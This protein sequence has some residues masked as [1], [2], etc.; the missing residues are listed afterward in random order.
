MIPNNTK[1]ASDKFSRMSYYVVTMVFENFDIFWSKM[2]KI[3]IEGYLKKIYQWYIC[4][5]INEEINFLILKVVRLIW[6]ILILNF[7]PT[8]C[9]NLSKQYSM[10]G[11][12]PNVVKGDIA[13]LG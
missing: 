9:I 2:E 8:Y 5:R 10:I 13:E 12:I 1:F 6:K 3:N 7:D 4:S 11:Y